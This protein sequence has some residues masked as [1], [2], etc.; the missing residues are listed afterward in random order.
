[1]P[2]AEPKET[3]KDK[4]QLAQLAQ[5]VRPQVTAP[6]FT[7]I[8]IQEWQEAAAALEDSNWSTLY[9]GER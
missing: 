7:P 4:A 9:S 2:P 3:G 1:M 8:H 5:L 6:V